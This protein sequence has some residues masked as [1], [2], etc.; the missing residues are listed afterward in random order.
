VVKKYFTLPGNEKGM[1]PIL[2][3]V[4]MLLLTIVL[5]GITVSAVYGDDLSTSLSSAPMAGIKAESEGS[6]GYHVGFDKNFIY[7][8][9][10][11]GEPLFTDS[12]KI[13]ITGEGKSHTPNFVGGMN[14]FGDV[15]ISYDN[16]L[17]NGKKSEY[18]S[19]NPVLSDGVWST[20]EGLVLNGEDSINGTSASS[21]SVSI[22]G[23]ENTSKNYGLKENSMITIKVF[24]I[25]TQRLI[26]EC[27]CKV[28]P[29]E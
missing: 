11:G 4:L 12:T 13:V 15:F 25:K 7:L 16:L 17:F 10:T 6:I 1:S 2:G 18:A 20:G 24:D 21:V 26:A 3:V 19:R 8:E 9:H 23:N 5:A 29:A 27:E 14:L 28:T 22:D